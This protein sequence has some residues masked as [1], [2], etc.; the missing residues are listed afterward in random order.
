MGGEFGEGFVKGGKVEDGVVAEA[1]G[2]AGSFQ[3]QAVCAIAGYGHRSAALDE[4]DRT[5]KVGG[6]FGV[7][8]ALQLLEEFGVSLGAG[9]RRSGITG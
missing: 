6:A 3:D 4:R 2:A 9:G 5:N 7:A 1:V 8:L